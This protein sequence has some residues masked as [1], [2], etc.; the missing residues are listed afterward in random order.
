MRAVLFAML[1]FVS[2]LA[3]AEETGDGAGCKGD[4]PFC[5]V[6]EQEKD[7]RVVAEEGAEEVAQDVDKPCCCDT[8]T[9]GKGECA[10]KCAS[11]CSEECTDCPCVDCPGGICEAC[12]CNGGDGDKITAA[13]AALLGDGAKGAKGCC[14]KAAVAAVAGDKCKCDPCKCVDCNCGS[15]ATP[16]VITLHFTT[17]D[18]TLNSPT[19]ALTPGQD[20]TLE[21][22]AY[23]DGQVGGA[24]SWVAPIDWTRQLFTKLDKTLQ[25]QVRVSCQSASASEPGPVSLSMDR[26]EEEWLLLGK[27]RQSVATGSVTLDDV[28]RR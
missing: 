15:Q 25:C 21:L 10:D 19:I 17:G 22:K 6:R 20:A 13:V 4:C 27:H 9:C 14:S 11:A 1:L 24:E 7:C 8:A 2:P 16:V 26:H 23:E 18:F 5:Q 28:T 12:P 3:M